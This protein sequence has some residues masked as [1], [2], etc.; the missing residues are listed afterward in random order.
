MNMK[1]IRLLIMGLFALCLFACDNEKEGA[2]PP[3]FQGFKYEPQVVHAGDKVTITAVQIQ[4]GVHLYGAQ[5]N[6]VL[7]VQTIE[8][9][10]TT[11]CTLSY[12]TPSGTHVSC[13]DNPTW[14][15]TIP[16]NTISGRYT[17]QFSAS[18]NNAADAEQNSYNGGTG[19]GCTGSINSISSTLY[20]RANGSFTLPVQ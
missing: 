12:S 8:N 4:Q 13:Y 19:T 2:R 5:H 20:S 11:E 15:V 16:A 1:T 14:E 18:W 9:G 6:W 3:V 7:K 17:C 10:E